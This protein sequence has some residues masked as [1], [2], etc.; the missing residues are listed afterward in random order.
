ML[1]AF[2]RMGIVFELTDPAYFRNILEEGFWGQKLPHLAVTWGCVG[3][4]EEW[5]NP[6][7][8]RSKQLSHV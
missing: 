6:G 8:F 5:A 4:V 1:P 7:H 3:D 2:L